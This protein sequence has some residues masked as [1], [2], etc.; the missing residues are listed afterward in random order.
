MLR[1]VR[2]GVHLD[3]SSPSR[4]IPVSCCTTREP[5]PNLAGAGAALDSRQPIFDVGSWR[6][7]WCCRWRSSGWSCLVVVCLIECPAPST[8]SWAPVTCVWWLAIGLVRGWRPFERLMVAHGLSSMTLATVLMT[9]GW[10]L[11]VGGFAML[12]G[13]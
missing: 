12:V 8:R 11:F 1:G 2:R 13:S 5:P 10:Q 4:S 9:G 3:L 6:A 7:Q